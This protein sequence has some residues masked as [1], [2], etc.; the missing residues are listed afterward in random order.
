ECYL[1]G[2]ATCLDCHVV[3]H[4]TDVDKNPQL[5]PDANALCTRCHAAEG[6]SLT[7]HTH[8]AEKSAGSSCVECH[9]PRTVFS[10][11]AEIRDHAMTIPVPENTLSHGIP[12]ACNSCHKDH[13]A[14]WTLARMKVWYGSDSRQ[15]LIRR[16]DDFTEGRAANPAAIP[17]LLA[18][19]NRPAEGP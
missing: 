15:K 3:P 16:A 12:N 10:I 11:K 1:K 14:A 4:N 5:R 17:K 18:I 9:M 6:K 19:L 13:D 7:A 8:H 2:K